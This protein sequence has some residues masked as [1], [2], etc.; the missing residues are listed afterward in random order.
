MN[1]KK[2]NLIFFLVICLFG[3]GQNKQLLYDFT[4]IPQSL[5]VNPGAKMSYQWFGGV[6][7]VSGTSLYAGAS[8]IAVGD[9]FATDGVDIN[10]KFR[11]RVV[12]GLSER[13]EFSGAFQLN[14]L[15]GGFRGKNKP[16]NFYTFG[17]YVEGD[18]IYY[19]PKD[20]AILGYEGNA[21]FLGYKFDISHLKG[22]G[23]VQSVYH[24]GINKKINN[25]LTFGI[26][27]KLYSSFVNFESLRNKGYFVT[28]QGQNNLISSTLSIDSKYKVSGVNRVKKAFEGDNEN[29]SSLISPF[30]LSGNLGLGVDLGFTYSLNKRTVVT[31]SVIDLGFTYHSE[32]VESY[33]LKGTSTFEGVQVILPD[34][35]ISP[36]DDF[37]QDLIDDIEIRIP[38]RTVTKSYISFK[39]TKVNASI[40]HNFGKEIPKIDECKCDYS[41]AASPYDTSYTNSIGGQLYV[42]NRPRGPQ[43]AFTGFYQRKLGNILAAKATYTLDKFS[44]T[45]VGLGMS[46]NAGPVNI[47]AMADNVLSYQ[48]LAN[49]HYASFQFGINI[50]SWGKK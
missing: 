9:I 33:E 27:F 35:L 10:V 44:Y 49:S 16:E 38:F 47:Y 34:A 22:R 42:I 29:V 3:Y 50:I 4:E 14:I 19:W 46:I 41:V 24:F 20:L 31:G 11:D 26:R 23:E 37:W 30:L 45:N 39:Q 36:N 48:N 13:D 2:L 1:L 5:L 15:N 17:L 8:G 18:I 25:R 12:Y 7:L 40:R 6:P 21:D 28:E 32:D 43:M